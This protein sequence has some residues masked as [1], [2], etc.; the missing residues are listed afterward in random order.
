VRIVLVVWHSIPR[1]ETHHSAARFRAGCR[2]R[3]FQSSSRSSQL[4]TPRSPIAPTAS[5]SSSLDLVIAMQHD[6]S[7]GHSATAGAVK[8]FAALKRRQVPGLPSHIE[9]LEYQA[10]VAFGGHRAPREG[11]G[12]MVRAR[13]AIGA[14]AGA[15]GV[16]I[17]HIEG[18]AV[19]AFPT[20]SGH[21]RAHF[22]A[23]AHSSRALRGAEVAVGLSVS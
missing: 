22:S 7:A 13:R 9:A 18:C 8:Q 20:R 1:R 17:E 6:P 11:P 21:N 16:L 15:E 3:L 19:G 23:R 14:A 5:S 10:A 12:V 2:A 4:S